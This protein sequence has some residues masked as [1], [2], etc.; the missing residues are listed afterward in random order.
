MFKVQD[1]AFGTI[2][3]VYG[4]KEIGRNIYFLMYCPNNYDKWVYMPAFNYQEV[5]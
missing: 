1:K 2:H 4:V 5:N 3:T